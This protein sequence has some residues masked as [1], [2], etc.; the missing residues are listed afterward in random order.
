ME[1]RLIDAEALLS[2][3]YSQKQATIARELKHKYA[4][5]WKDMSSKSIQ[6]WRSLSE[7]PNKD[8]LEKLCTKVAKVPTLGILNIPEVL[9]RVNLSKDSILSSNAKKVYNL[10]ML[11]D[12]ASMPCSKK[13]GDIYDYLVKDLKQPTVS[14]ADGELTKTFKYLPCRSVTIPMLVKA[15]KPY[16]YKESGIMSGLENLIARGLVTKV[17]YGS[18]DLYKLSFS[19]IRRFLHPES[20]SSQGKIS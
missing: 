19:G 12:G 4:G 11:S 1:S 14:Y 15:G 18:T 17:H 3:V 16:E 6:R 9:L 8:N 13:E 2:V 20:R 5:D 7:I 10:L